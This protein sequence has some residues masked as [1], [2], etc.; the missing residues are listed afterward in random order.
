LGAAGQKRILGPDP[1]AYGLKAANRNN[2]DT[3]LR[4][5]AK[6]GLVERKVSVGE[7]FAASDPPDLF[8]HPENELRL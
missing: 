5:M 8:R 7:L 2:L 3:L 1:W 4:Y 6:Q